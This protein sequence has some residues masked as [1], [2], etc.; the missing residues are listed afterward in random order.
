MIGFVAGLVL[1][2]GA[3]GAMPG[4]DSIPRDA[5][6]DSLRIAETK[7]LLTWRRQWLTD[8]RGKGTYL[9][10]ASLHCHNDGSWKSGAPN[11]IRS[12]DSNR[13]FCPVWFPVD[14]SLPSDENQGVDASLSDEARQIMRRQRAG[15]IDRFQAAATADPSNAWIA[16]QVVRLAVD[17]KELDVARRNARACT[18][19]RPWCLLLEGYVE[20]AAG[21]IAHAD[22]VFLR[23]ASAMNDRDR[24]E[25][26]SIAPLLESRARA[27]YERIA[28]SARDSVDASFWWLADPLYLEP[29]NARRAE[30]FARQVLVRLHAAVGID[31][32]WDW[33]RRSGGDALAS[34]IVRYG[35]PT[36]LYWA[37]YYED[38]GHFGWLGF[39]DN[40]V[41]VAPEYELP[42]YHSAPAWSAVLDPSALNA[43]DGMRF[44]P[45]MGYGA[46]DWENDYWPPEHALRRLGPILDLPEQLVI[47]R[48]DNDALLAIGMD[49]PQ[50]FF[51]PGVRMQ[52]DAAVILSQDPTD[53]WVP[54][55]ESLTLDGKGTTV[56]VSPLAPRAQVVSAELAPA[57]GGPGLAVRIRRAVHP[58]APLSVLK[59]GEVAISD[60]L[61]F[62][63]GDAPDLPAN[64]AEAVGKM[65]G[66]LAFNDKRVGIFW[67]TYGVAP[68]DTVDVAIR[69]ANI[70]KPSFL[71]RVG[72]TFG[73]ADADGGELTIR[74]REPRANRRDAVIWAGDVPIQSRSVVLEVSRLR[75]GR[76][77][78][79]VTVA[80][81]GGV[82]VST[83]RDVT[84]V[85]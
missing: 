38:N 55:R 54:S 49:V 46:V 80:R 82:P 33:S 28:C 9:R 31:E 20:H 15:L 37:G 40:A 14:D 65:F 61:F 63:P 73:I 50:K 62:R 39:H 11:I 26:T 59:D 45:R 44:A 43:G 79:E 1:Q 77:T 8:R 81:L 19:A 5:V 42:R 3:Y 2:I 23:A 22:S 41:N 51:A 85:R 67:E 52:Y 7:F 4:V 75:P 48:R 84:F 16:G 70:D 76:Y 47:F 10:L 66:S 18:A 64:A 27:A 60:P 32:R 17:Q 78:V 56:L 57:D 83:I 35:W 21:R 53:R 71:R 72:A 6:T 69:V 34:M 36:H 74:W 13:S 25:W 24:C 58:P 30:H 68:G 29:G 12:K